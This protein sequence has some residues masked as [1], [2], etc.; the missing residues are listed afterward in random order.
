[1]KMKINGKEVVAEGFA[2][3]GCHKIYVLEQDS[4]FEEAG[5]V[6]YDLYEI[7]GLQDAYEDACPLKFI[8]NWKLDTS[9]V[10]QGE[11]AKFEY[12]DSI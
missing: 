3:D 12:G 11:D 6:G 8:S 9:F 5:E 2:F 7:D 10:G 1:M 4:D